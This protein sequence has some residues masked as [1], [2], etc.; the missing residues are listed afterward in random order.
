[1]GTFAARLAGVM[2]LLIGAV[3]VARAEVAMSGTFTATQVCPAYQ[4][5]RKAT[6]PG[7][8]KLEVNKA[9]RLI[10]KNK[11]DATHYRIMV[12]GA[13]PVERW[14][15]LACGSVAATGE[16]AHEQAAP[17]LLPRPARDRAS[18]RRTCSP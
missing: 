14:V 11:P 7:D 13:Q 6:N 12:E 17:K 9:Y 10:G 2:A 15:A 16:T 8:V 3:G 1:M 18:A 5:F 4:S